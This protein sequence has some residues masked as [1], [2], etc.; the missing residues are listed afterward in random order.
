MAWHDFLNTKHDV[1]EMLA[2][3]KISEAGYDLQSEDGQARVKNMTKRY[4]NNRTKEDIVAELD[5]SYR[6]RK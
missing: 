5:Q 6:N 2:M 1:A 3:H 4:A